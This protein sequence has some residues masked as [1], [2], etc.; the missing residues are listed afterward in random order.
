[1]LLLKREPRLDPRHQA[2]LYQLQA[3]EAVRN[4]EYAALFHEQGLGKTK[5]GLD[6]ALTWLKEGVVDLVLIVTK[7][8]L[9][10]N[11]TDEVKAHTYF[12]AR[13]LGQDRNANFFAFNS[14]AR[15]YLAH[16]EVLKSE[17]RRFALFQK[18]R[19]IGVIL[20]EAQKIKNPE[21]E[22]TK[23][24]HKLAPGF[25][26]RVIMTGTPV[27]NRP[28]DIWA[29]IKFLDAGESLGHSFSK[30]REGLDLTNE[31]ADDVAGRAEFEDQLS[32]VFAKIQPFTVRETK[33]TAGI[34][35]PEKSIENVSV[36]LET[37]QRDLYQRFRNELRAEV[38]RDGVLVEDD[39]EEILKRLLRLV[40]VASNP[41]LVD[42]GYRGEPGKFRS[43]HRLVE[44][45]LAEGSKAVVW[46]SFIDNASWLGRQFEPFGSAVVHGKKSIRERNDAI[47]AFKRDPECR[48]LVATPASAK[49]GLTL[50]VATHAVFFDRSFSLDDYLQAQD[51]IHRIS[52]NKPCYI[53]NLVASD[54]VDDWVDM[55]LAAKHLAAQ[56]AQGDINQEEYRRRANYDFGRAVREILGGD[57]ADE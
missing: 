48:V 17:E 42:E 40:Q 56:L 16:Y 47:D 36:A 55:L 31:L 9:I 34:E 14:P 21:A 57:R 25:L 33:G 41:L 29:Q 24:F 13:I 23:S 39:A 11:W 2:F 5:I 4:L 46:T 19:R 44:R 35:L 28:F 6:L 45:A 22:L 27:A 53:W 54:T 1:M 7:R 18:T 8:S 50:T 37:Q 52:Q 51:R 49:E 12:E 30:F 20:D 15:L 38:I 43:A 10:K 32:T 3:I 26:R